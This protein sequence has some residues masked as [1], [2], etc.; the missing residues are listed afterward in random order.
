MMPSISWLFER[1]HPRSHPV[2]NCTIGETVRPHHGPSPSTE[3]CPPDGPKT[4]APVGAILQQPMSAGPGLGSR[5]Q[6]L[7]VIAGIVVVAVLIRLFLLGDRVAHWDEARIAFWVL[8]YETSG[9]W[10][11]H[12]VFHGPLLVHVEQ[13]VFAVLGPT[14]FAMRLPA[15]LVGG[16]LP[17]VVWLFRDHLRDREVVGMALLLAANPMFLYYS[18]FM[19]NDILVSTFALATLGFVLRTHATGRGR[20]AAAAGLSFALALGSKENAVLYLLAWVGSGGLLVAWRYRRTRASSER[21]T[22]EALREALG[23]PHVVPSLRH[24]TIAVAVMLP[25]LWVIYLPRGSGPGTLDGLLQNPGTFPE[26]L[27]AGLVTPPV[28]ALS[29][30]ALG[31]A[32]GEYPSYVFFGLLIGLLLIGAFATVLLGVIGVWRTRP[33]DQNRPI[34]AFA[35]LWAVLSVLGYPAA[36]DLMAGWTALHVV[37]PLTIPAAVGLVSLWD[38]PVQWRGRVS[39]RRTVL[40]L[41][42]TYL[43]LA[44]GLT[45]FVAPGS[46]YNPIGQPSQMDAEAGETIAAM[47]TRIDGTWKEGAGSEGAGHDVAYVGSYWESPVHRL[48]FLWYV[49]RNSGA[50][51]FVDDVEA[52]GAHPPPVIISHAD[53]QATIQN[54]YPA[55]VCYT[56]ERVPWEGGHRSGLPGE[57]MVCLEE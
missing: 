41:V 57:V 44:G 14:D 47:E 21:R 18:R 36:A 52:L 49:E 56:H 23:F 20:Y 6:T 45:S 10:T 13:W 38:R 42:A 48:P 25:I 28:E 32:Q 40:V 27:E 12:P 51:M 5:L 16:T 34:L 31:S 17:G 11:Y 46:P 37:I 33:S 26:A 1:A 43:L 22:S 24:G 29:F 50:R 15:A 54:R 7:R 39:D 3:S 8:Q 35:G 19:R 30:W 55:Y 2:P 9:T 53:R 4:Y